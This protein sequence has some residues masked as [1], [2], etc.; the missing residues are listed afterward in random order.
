MKTKTPN[1]VKLGM[2][3]LEV[4][5]IAFGA[6]ELGGEWGRVDED[7]AIAAIR[8]A[9]SLGV[10]LFDTAQGYG[11][12]ASERVLGRALRDLRR[13]PPAVHAAVVGDRALLPTLLLHQVLDQEPLDRIV[14]GDVTVVVPV[15]QRRAADLVHEVG[16]RRGGLGVRAGAHHPVHEPR[17]PLGPPARRDGQ[18]PDPRTNL[19]LRSRPSRRPLAAACGLAGG[20][21]P[22]SERWST[23][24]HAGSTAQPTTRAPRGSGPRASSL[25]AQLAVVTLPFTR[26]C[27]DPSGR[28]HPVQT[29][30]SPERSTFASKRVATSATPGVSERCLGEV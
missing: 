4:F 20:A 21:P 13:D 26:S 14:D 23:R 2:T 25:A 1:P 19:A 22:S 9:R 15:R 12:G 16:E 6:W 18:I 27:P 17:R 29:W 24:T 8:H 5:P 11:F 3:G 28:R 10:N 7:A 30:C